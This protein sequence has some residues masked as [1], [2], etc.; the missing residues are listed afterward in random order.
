MQLIIIIQGVKKSNLCF[1]MV[2][3]YFQEYNI[4]YI[5]FTI[6]C[7]NLFQIARC[8]VCLIVMDICYALHF[9]LLIIIIEQF[10]INF[11]QYICK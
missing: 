3:N 11:I 9:V 5:Q 10:V 8:K 1:I 6:T 2:L 4:K 7:E